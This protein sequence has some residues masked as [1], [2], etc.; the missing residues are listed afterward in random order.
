MDAIIEHFNQALFRFLDASPSPFHAAR[1]LADAL[2]RNGFEEL[3]E[4]RHWN[5]QIPGKYYVRRNASSLIAFIRGR[6]EPAEHGFRMFG[7]H[8]DSPCLRIKPQPEKYKYTYLQLGVEVYG[9]ALLKPWFDRDLS[10]AGRIVFRNGENL[11]SGLLDFQRAVAVIPSLAIHLDRDASK[12]QAVNP[13]KHIP[14]LFLQ[15]ES[16]DEPDFRELLKQELVAQYPTTAVDEVLDFELSLYDMAK[17]GYVG[18]K[19]DFITS[20]RLDNLISCFTGLE[21]IKTAGNDTNVLLVCN[22]HEETGSVSHAGAQGTFLNAVLERIAGTRENLIRLIDKSLLISADNTH[23]IHPNYP[24]RHDGNH[25]PLLNKGPAIKV[26]ACQR[27]A[28]NSETAAVVRNLAKKA[29]I[30]LQMFITRSDIRCGS[31]IGPLTAA[32]TGV[33]TVDVG[34]PTFAMHSIRETAGS[35]D[36]YY[37]YRLVQAFFA[38]ANSIRVHSL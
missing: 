19:R 27:Y 32:Q 11:Q 4:S 14:P 5:L 17:A 38:Q 22:D 13:Q 24:D 1:S 15:W 16:G 35:K 2:D 6:Q 18:F 21:A 29:G 37:L 25:G 34:V 26:N 9:S 7:A 31:T 8:T 20:A 3:D 33:K 10:M 30:P 12:Q 36:P 23:G 28:S